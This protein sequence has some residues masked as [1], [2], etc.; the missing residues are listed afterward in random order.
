MVAFSIDAVTAPM[1]STQVWPPL[2]VASEFWTTCII[3]LGMAG[4]EI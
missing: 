4:L 2:A 1:R 3:Q